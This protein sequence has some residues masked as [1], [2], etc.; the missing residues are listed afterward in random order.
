MNLNGWL[1]EANKDADR[2]MVPGHTSSNGQ[3]TALRLATDL[4]GIDKETEQLIDPLCR[5]Q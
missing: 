4:L 1:E 5:A 3:P 2:S